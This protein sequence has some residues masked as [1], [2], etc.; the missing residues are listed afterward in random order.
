LTD[1]EIAAVQDDRPKT[2]NYHVNNILGKLPA[3]DR[4]LEKLG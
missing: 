2:V 1:R 3:I 4:P